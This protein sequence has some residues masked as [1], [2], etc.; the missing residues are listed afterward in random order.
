MKKFKILYSYGKKVIVECP[1]CKERVDVIYSKNQWVESFKGYCY[2]CGWKFILK[3]TE[4]D[5]IQPDSPFFEMIYRFHPERE[6]EMK[7]RKHK[8]EEKQ[9][10][11]KLEQKYWEERYDPTQKHIRHK[12]SER[13]AIEK[14]VL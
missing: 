13:R 7:E 14:E 10:K 5:L 8:W 2:P 9:H 6:A 1:N 3:D 4:F 12:A 11:A